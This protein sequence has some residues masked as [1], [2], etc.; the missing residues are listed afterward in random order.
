MAN[1]ITGNPWFIDTTGIIWHGNVYVKTI[2][3]NR[4]TA[5]DA[6]KIVDDAG[7]TILD[8]VANTNDPMFDFGTMSWVGGFNVVTL[9]SG[10]LTVFINK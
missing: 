10:V 5:G 6:L 8:T 4:P 2:V 1:N 3:W 9:A 7:R